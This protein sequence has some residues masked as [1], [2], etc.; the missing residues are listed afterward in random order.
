MTEELHRLMDKGAPQTVINERVAGLL[1][2]RKSE[3]DK[4]ETLVNTIVSDH[5]K[6][7]RYLERSVTYAMGGAAILVLIWEV[8][9][10]F[11]K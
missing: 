11:M 6:R 9:K 7:L 2:R 8:I 10:A 1:E 5:E 3:H 4:L